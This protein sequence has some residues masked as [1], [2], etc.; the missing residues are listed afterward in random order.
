LFVAAEK[1]QLA[2]AKHLLIYQA[3]PNAALNDGATPL[4]VA[5]Q[6]GYREMVDILLSPTTINCT[7]NVCD[8]SQTHAANATLL[9]Y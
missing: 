4:F 8:V 6:N 7:R 5:C 2:V 1:H 9:Q 3:D